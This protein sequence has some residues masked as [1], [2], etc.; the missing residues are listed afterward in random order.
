MRSL[1]CCITS[2]ALSFLSE[3]LCSLVWTGWQEAHIISACKSYG[4]I[5]I[6]NI[7]MKELFFLSAFTGGRNSRVRDWHRWAPGADGRGAENP[8]ARKIVQMNS[9]SLLLPKSVALQTDDNDGAL[10]S[11]T[12]AGEVK[13]FNTWVHIWLFAVWGINLTTSSWPFLESNVAT[14]AVKKQRPV[15]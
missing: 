4:K 12:Q 6:S 7:V 1:P 11:S 3:W 8:T 14:S 5:S 9:Y 15:L 13:H 2:F 10:E